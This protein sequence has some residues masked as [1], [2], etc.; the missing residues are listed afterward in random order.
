MNG[1]NG[2]MKP[3]NAFEPQ[4]ARAATGR[5]L[6]FAPALPARPAVNAFN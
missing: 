2:S 1:K 6:G 4:Q 5:R 3:K